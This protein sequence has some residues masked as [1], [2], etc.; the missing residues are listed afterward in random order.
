ME[1][2]ATKEV[3]RR[4]CLFSPFFLSSD[5]MGVQKRLW[6]KS[7]EN[8]YIFRVYLGITGLG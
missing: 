3:K 2:N 1:I 4:Q 7:V 6:L 8:P 5:R